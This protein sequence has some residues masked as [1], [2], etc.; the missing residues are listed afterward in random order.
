MKRAWVNYKN[1]VDCRRSSQKLSIAV[2]MKYQEKLQKKSLS[3]LQAY[4]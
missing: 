3:G 1:Y 2:I 4:R